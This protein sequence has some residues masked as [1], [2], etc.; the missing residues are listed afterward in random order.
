MG[1]GNLTGL[2]GSGA[3]GNLTERVESVRV[4]RFIGPGRVGSGRIRSCRVVSGHPDPDPAREK[5]LPP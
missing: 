3:V 2:V 1:V 4:S 5:R